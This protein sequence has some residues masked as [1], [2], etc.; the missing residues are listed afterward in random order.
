MKTK[1]IALAILAIAAAG[2]AHA[3]ENRSEQNK[4]TEPKAA[5]VVTPVQPTMKPTQDPAI[6][7][8]R[9]EAMQSRR[10]E[11][12]ERMSRELGLN[13]EQKEKL[14]EVDAKHAVT[15]EELRT[16]QDRDKMQE[17]ARMAREE[18]EAKLKEILTPEQYEKMVSRRGASRQNATNKETEIK[19]KAE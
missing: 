1:I 2:S 3:Q 15:L 17:G 12:S 11:E 9:A 16:S 8:Q 14:K 18:R 7:K 6:R 13:E 19:Q 5:E 4:I 10:A